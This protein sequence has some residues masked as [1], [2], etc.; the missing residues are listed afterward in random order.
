MSLGECRILHGRRSQYSA[1][2]ARGT[3]ANI[4]PP[5][6]TTPARRSPGIAVPPG[7]TLSEHLFRNPPG[8][9][10]LLPNPPVGPGQTLFQGDLWFPAQHPPQPGVVAVSPADALGLRRVIPLHHPLPRD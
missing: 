7:G 1:T 8:L 10:E 2:F 3:P 4:S 9:D 6:F 5:S